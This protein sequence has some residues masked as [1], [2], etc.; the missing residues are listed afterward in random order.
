MQDLRCY[1]HAC[2]A[3]QLEFSSLH[4]HEAEKSVNVV[5]GEKHSFGVQLVLL[6]NFHKPVDENGP[7]R[8]RN[9]RLFCHVVPLGQ[10]VCLQREKRDR[11]S[12]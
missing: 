6:P 9:V 8:K 10:K 4:R 2:R 1:E 5:D 7:H 12:R 3:H 11:A